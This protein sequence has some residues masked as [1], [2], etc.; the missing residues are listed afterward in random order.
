MLSQPVFSFIVAKSLPIFPS[1][2]KRF[3]RLFHRLG[4]VPT[5][6]IMWMFPF[7][8]FSLGDSFSLRWHYPDNLPQPPPKNFNKPAGQGF[9]SGGSFFFSAYSTGYQHD[10]G[11]KIPW[12]LVDWAA[13]TQR[14]TEVNRKN[15]LQQ[16]ESSYY[17]IY[18]HILLTML[19][20]IGGEVV[21][22]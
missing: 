3:W 17:N 1:G 4:V 7:P 20:A 21:M 13:K 11:K 18:W 22:I 5:N 14:C 8:C 2:K 12:V 9:F 15:G 10:K 16:E 6:V 19:L